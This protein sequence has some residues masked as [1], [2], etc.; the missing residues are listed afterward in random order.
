MEATRLHKLMARQGV[1]SLRA[2]ERLI[3]EGRVQVNG[4]VVTTPGALAMP[5]D[6]IRVDGKLVE[7][8]RDLRYFVLNK[9]RGVVSTASDELGRET[10][11]DLVPARERLYPVG[12]LDRDSEG[13]MLLTND[14]TLAERLMHPRYGAHKQYRVEIEGPV[15]QDQ[16]NQL[17]AGVRLSDGLSRPLRAEL[18]RSTS[19]RSTLLVTMGEGR[20]RQVRRTLEAL[21]LRVITL[22][23]L[24]LGPLDLRGLGSGRSRELSPKEVNELRQ[25]AGLPTGDGQR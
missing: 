15:T 10:V 4:Q 7:S 20:N 23:R 5:D 24:K 19:A 12:R 2:C 16:L 13:L 3:A 1:A 14:G 21:G 8:P 18:L 25:A 9:P 6:E 17:R 11:L 22:A